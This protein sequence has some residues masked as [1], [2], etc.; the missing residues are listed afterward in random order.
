MESIVECEDC[1]LKFTKQ[2]MLIKH[3][4][5]SKYCQKY[6]NILFTCLSCNFSTV[7]FKNIEK[8]DPVRCQIKNEKDKDLIARLEKSLEQEK[9]KSDAY[10]KIIENNIKVAH[11]REEQPIVQNE[12]PVEE[13]QDNR[14]E[15]EQIEDIIFKNLMED[16]EYNDNLNNLKK[17]KTKLIT[18]ISL[19]AYLD[20]LNNHLRIIKN[21]LTKKKVNEYKL[22]SLLSLSLTALDKKL[23]TFGNY[24]SL[25]VDIDDIQKLQSC[26][27][28]NL[29]PIQYVPFKKEEAVNKFLNY[30]TGLFTIKQIIELQLFNSGNKY[31]NVIYLPLKKSTNEDPYSF[32][33][34]ESIGENNSIVWKMDCRL[35]EISNYFLNNLRSYLIDLFRRIYKNAFNDNDYRPNFKNKLIINESEQ[36]IQN[37]I[38]LN[39][40]MKFNLL[41][42]NI[43]KAK[44]SYEK[45][46]SNDKFKL[47]CD[48]IMQKQR[49]KE[50]KDD[51]EE[52]N[53]NM[54]LLFDTITEEEVDSLIKTFSC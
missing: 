17:L 25:Q 42:R 41:F 21:I 52:I 13:V 35:E 4:E 49:F 16:N 18:K 38:I 34:L 15:I 9:I 8:H 23:L 5:T 31:N 33:F 30:A 36:I 24:T 3:K 37:L 45:I 43:V 6:K 29:Y 48:D 19:Q 20:M 26:L 54:K 7:G 12:L 22:N 51:P 32:Y 1:L 39:Q 28:N 40:P 14:N 53:Y 2:E 44:S 11:V 46:K 50:E 10:L 27:K 47:T